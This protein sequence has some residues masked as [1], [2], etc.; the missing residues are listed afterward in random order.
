MRPVFS[1][2]FAMVLSLLV[3]SLTLPTVHSIP[4]L[5]GRFET[6]TDVQ[7]L[8]NLGLDAADMREATDLATKETIYKEVR[9]PY[10][11]LFLELTGESEVPETNIVYA[12]LRLSS[13]FLLNCLLLC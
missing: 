10:S 11:M 3:A 9:M 5:G 1:S 2:T 7:D 12:I 13:P 6:T 4:L 8:L